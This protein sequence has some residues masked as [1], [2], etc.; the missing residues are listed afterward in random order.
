MVSIAKKFKNTAL[1]YN[2]KELPTEGGGALLIY[3]K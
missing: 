1:L 2:E 3:Q